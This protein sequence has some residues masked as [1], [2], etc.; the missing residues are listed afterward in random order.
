MALESHLAV[1]IDT[2]IQK[3][4]V[5]FLNEMYNLNR[6]VLPIVQEKALQA[7]DGCVPPDPRQRWGYALLGAICRCSSPKPSK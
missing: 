3:L 6:D 1:S 7:S 2:R 4:Q 5:T